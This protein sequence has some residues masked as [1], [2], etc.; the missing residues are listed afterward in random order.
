MAETMIGM[1]SQDVAVL[2]KL[3]SMQEQ[4]DAGGPGEPC[5]GLPGE[6]PYSVRNLEALLGISKS[7]I[8]ERR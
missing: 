8:N 5:R 1:K 7:E 3:V 6:D 4:E 2:L